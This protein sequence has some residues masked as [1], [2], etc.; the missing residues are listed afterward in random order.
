MFPAAHFFLFLF[1]LIGVGWYVS[2]K[3]LLPRVVFKAKPTHSFYLCIGIG[4]T[5]AIRQL[6]ATRQ[7]THARSASLPSDSTKRLDVRSR[8]KILALTGLATPEDKKRAFSSGVD[9]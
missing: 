7:S 2:L 3:S 8:L 1:S 5:K 6:E 4:A 9:G